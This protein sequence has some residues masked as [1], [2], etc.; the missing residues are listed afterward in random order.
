[1]SQDKQIE[2]LRKV[3]DF[4]FAGSETLPRPNTTDTKKLMDGN[5]KI[6]NG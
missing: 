1:M 3:L 2:I 6:T 5:H 4:P